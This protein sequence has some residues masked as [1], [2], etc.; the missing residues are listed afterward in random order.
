MIDFKV[1][2]WFFA[3]LRRGLPLNHTKEHERE[4]YITVNLPHWVVQ[5]YY[6]YPVFLRD[7]PCDFV[8]TLHRR[9]R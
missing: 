8:A 2:K 5:V 7:L 3:A 9:R 1:C 4:F 6:Q